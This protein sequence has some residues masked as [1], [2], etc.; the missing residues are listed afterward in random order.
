MAST[1]EPLFSES[2]PIQLRVGRNDCGQCEALSSDTIGVYGIVQIDTSRLETI[3]L[4]ELRLT[5]RIEGKVPRSEVMPSKTISSRAFSEKR[6][7][8]WEEG[9]VQSLPGTDTL[10]LPFSIPLPPNTPPSTKRRGNLTPFNVSYHLTLHVMRKRPRYD[11]DI[12]R[13]IIILPSLTRAARESSINWGTGGDLIRENSFHFSRGKYKGAMHMRICLAGQDRPFP[14]DA[15]K[16]FPFSV[17]FTTF[18]LP[19]EKTINPKSGRDSPA[20]TPTVKP[21]DRGAL[22]RLKLLRRTTVLGDQSKTYRDV[23]ATLGKL[24]DA[25]LVLDRVGKQEWIQYPELEGKGRW[26]QQFVFRSDF[27]LASKTVIPSFKSKYFNVS[28]ELELSACL[29]LYI[30]SK[31]GFKITIPVEIYRPGIENHAYLSDSTA[32]PP[33]IR[34]QMA[35]TSMPSNDIMN[36]DISG[37]GGASA[38]LDRR[39]YAWN[40]QQIRQP[41]VA[42]VSLSVM[43]TSDRP[44]ADRY[45]TLPLGAGGAAVLSSST[46]QLSDEQRRARTQNI[47]QQ[48]QTLQQEMDNL[49]IAPERAPSTADWNAQDFGGETG[50][51][52]HNPPTV[53][54]DRQDHELL[55]DEP[56]PSYDMI[57]TLE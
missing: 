23:C 56:P 51:S 29:P 53:S 25:A 32:A 16:P 22:L 18:S 47:E 4:A 24:E 45:C 52:A 38:T 43:A 42:G 6:L 49:G 12:Q 7:K 11:V 40:E 37:Y 27:E 20:L 10:E 44:Y 21:Q 39:G 41:S 14:L 31:E 8:I 2:R 33:Y 5:S 50:M 17:T 57:R 19:V 1:L 28:Y 26:V 36:Q 13:E 15:Q 9:N 35:H 46:S 54:R 3:C 34:G 30:A 48:I 55:P